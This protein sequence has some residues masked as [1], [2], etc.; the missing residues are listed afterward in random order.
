MR[1]VKTLIKYAKNLGY[2]VERTENNHYKLS[3]YNNVLFMGSTPSDGR[4]IKKLKN[5]LL[6]ISEGMAVGYFK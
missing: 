2:T 4:R 1:E 3:G 6:K 5:T